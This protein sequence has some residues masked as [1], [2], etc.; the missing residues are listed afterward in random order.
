ME[1]LENAVT[2]L[3]TVFNEM[4]QLRLLHGEDNKCE[5]LNEY[6]DRVKNPVIEGDGWIKAVEQEGG[7]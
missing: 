5:I 6:K 3:R 2:K 4:E 7:K 1:N